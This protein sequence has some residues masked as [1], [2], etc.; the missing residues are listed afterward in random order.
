MN[1]KRNNKSSY[2]FRMKAL[3][4]VNDTNKGD[5][6]VILRFIYSHR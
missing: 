2:K 1:E 4:V 6:Y 5:E 3:I